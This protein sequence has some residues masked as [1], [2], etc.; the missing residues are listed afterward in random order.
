MELEGA[1]KAGQATRDPV[2]L[3]SRRVKKERG[4][5]LSQHVRNGDLEE[6]ASKEAIDALSCPN[7][8]FSGC[9]ERLCVCVC[10]YRIKF[11]ACC[12]HV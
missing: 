2:L 6:M 12:Q 3:S 1:V 11:S 5:F 7:L 10:V 4:A 9:V 8:S